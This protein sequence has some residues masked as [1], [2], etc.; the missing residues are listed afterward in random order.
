MSRGLVLTC[1]LLA[2]ALPIAP[3]ARAQVQPRVT[4]EGRVLDESTGLGVPSA[5]VELEGRVV[6]TENDGTFRFTDVPA[7]GYRLLVVAFGYAARSRDLRFRDDVSVTVEL[8]PA[9][10]PIEGV[11]ATFVEVEGRVRDPV[12]D[13]NVVDAVVLTNQGRGVATDAHGRFKLEG[14]LEGAPLRL[15]IESFGYVTVDTVVV[16]REDEKYLFDL[17]L[18]SVVQA[19]IAVQIER[20]EKR[21]APAFTPGRRNLNRDDLLEYAGNHTVQSMFLFEYGPRRGS[22]VATVYVDGER[23]SLTKAPFEELFA[24]LPET[25]ERIEFI[26]IPYVCARVDIYT[27]EFMRELI[28]REGELPPVCDGIREDPWANPSREAPSFR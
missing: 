9:P 16:A 6:L 20:L 18:D 10:V 11:G 3:Q 4:V 12:N 15:T 7:G 24:L 22:R 17:E 26:M 14:M 25:I 28:A 5:T 23:W 21:A 2:L 8:E 1:A 27:R 13:F 19:Q